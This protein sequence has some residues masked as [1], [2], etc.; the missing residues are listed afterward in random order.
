MPNQNDDRPDQTIARFLKDHLLSFKEIMFESSKQQDNIAVWLVGMSTGSIALI[1]SQFGKF[2]PSLYLALKISVLFLATTIILG[3]LFRI[4]HLFLQEHDRND[5]MRI[6]GWLTGYGEF[7]TEIPIELPEGSSAEFIALCLYHYMGTDV[8]PEFIESVKIKG[9]VEHWRNQYEE[10]AKS[11]RNLE[12][13]KGQVVE[14]MVENF[15][16]FLARLEGVSPQQFKQTIENDK[17]TG[18]RK[19]R[20][21]KSCNIFYILMCI[22]FAVSVSFI[23]CSFISIDLKVNNSS[24]PTDQKSIAP[25]KQVQPMPD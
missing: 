4:F 1:I 10:Y 25:S 7:S 11:H 13:A 20:L 3:L 2:N 18:I 24:A 23:S 9:D 15:H 8:E 16:E 5:L 21:K 14:G 12:E 19:R 6:N 17:S 22:S